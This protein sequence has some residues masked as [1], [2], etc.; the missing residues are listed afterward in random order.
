VHTEEG[1]FDASFRCLID[2]ALTELAAELNHITLLGAAERQAVVAGASAAITD[3]VRRKVSRLL[4]LELNAAR[5]T[6]TL[7]GKDSA[8]RWSEFLERAAH[9]SFW[10]SLTPHY[11]T[12]LSRLDVLIR[13]RA[14]AASEFA[15]RFAADR[16]RLGML[17]PGA[18]EL[19]RASF[20][21]GDSHRGG[22]SVIV[23][24]LHDQR[25]IY[26]PRALGID[27]AISA[28]L[29]QLYSSIPA[30]DRIRVPEVI[31]CGAY[32]WSE[33]IPHRYC[34]SAAELRT[35]YTRLGHW[36]ALARFFGTTDLH[37]ENL[38]ACGP[39]PVVID[40][41]TLFTPS[42]TVKPAG[43]GD[44]LDQAAALLAGTVL[45]SGL[46]PGRGVDL[47]WRGV[48]ISAAGALPGQQ[49]TMQAPQIVD[50]GTD[51]A[52]LAM[53]PVPGSIALNHPSPSPDLDLYWP[54]VLEGF[55]ELTGRLL[56]LDKAGSLE[57]AFAA[58]RDT[59]IRAVLRSTEAYS[60][61]GRMLWHPVSL[62]DEAGAVAR[63]TA[64]LAKQS[65]VAPWAPGDPAVIAAEVADLL[66]GDIPFFATTPGTGWLRG[67]RNTVWGQ[68]HDVLA[69]TLQRWRSA[70]HL[71][72]RELIQSSLVCAYIND[73]FTS[74]GTA[75][76]VEQ[77][78]T[79]DLSTRR[80]QL[81]AG[82]LDRLL[83]TAIRGA[84]G[85]A[86]WIAPVMNVT[87]WSVQPLSADAY[88]GAPGIA[89]LIG[90]YLHEEAAG[91]ALRIDGL[92][93]LLAATLA[94]MRAA[95]DFRVS[96][97]QSS[98]RTRPQPPGLY[99]GLHSQIWG[100]SLLADLG[101]VD[102]AEAS[103]RAARLAELLPEALT[104]TAESDLLSGR[105]GAVIGSVRMA[106]RTSQ[107]GWLELAVAAGEQLVELA[108]LD[109]GRACWNSPLWPVGV[110]GFAH[111]AT[112]IGWA[113]A[114][115]SQATR[116]T[117]FAAMA[118]AAFAYEDSL[119]DAS[120]GGW[121]DV[122]EESGIA[123]AWCHGATGI[124]LAAADLIS[125]GFGD[126]AGHL[127]VVRRAAAGC[128]DGGMG[129]NHT[130]CHGDLG[131]WELLDTAF[132]LGVAPTGI[133]RPSVAAYIIGSIEKYGAA[134]GLARAAFCPGL[135]PGLGGVAYQ[136]LRMDPDCELPSLL[137]PA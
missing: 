14:A 81:A 7:Q 23:L 78:V 103:Y 80:R 41:E 40:C 83:R 51:L 60:E 117:D 74:S 106:A 107:S 42:Q 62:H 88:S 115:L 95:D 99:V 3:A 75:M 79:D 118:E 91:R 13:G 50:A 4:L 100:W 94:S 15:G 33:F 10:E 38:I 70:D 31:L 68:P 114:R 128:W 84:D 35:Y 8:A 109:D 26:K 43:M 97:R 65:E 113:L 46:L 24:E 1:D 77:P 57:P 124:G 116:R 85:T 29:G 101:A 39:T 45:R 133:D 64:L 63:A 58:F 16:G 44:A 108:V 125:C 119:W 17:I 110:G 104:E 123:T 19:S 36:L 9:R 71:I 72:E 5:V 129:W 87:G 112:G 135:M 122:R 11:P 98:Y 93:E 30:A 90:S 102:P 120:E 127:D 89:V 130:I 126:A 49:P 92:P 61:I 54:N 69:E 76:S 47:G 137:V 82:I 6:G 134:S 121:R 59:D 66:V 67:P 20:G 132:A 55:D 21:A 136:L 73:G 32:G 86:T 53:A 2:P 12:L 105:A 52:R 56:A 131:C 96:S 22:R 48:D 25:L 37:A 27:S 28:F 111:G 18:G 34:E